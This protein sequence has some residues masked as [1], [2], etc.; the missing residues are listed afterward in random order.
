[1]AV[2]ADCKL[3]DVDCG[4]DGLSIPIG[5]QWNC[6]A[7][8]SRSLRLAFR[9]RC[10]AYFSWFLSASSWRGAAVKKLPASPR[11]SFTFPRLSVTLRGLVAE[12]EGEPVGAAALVWA[13]REDHIGIPGAR[14]A[15]VRRGRVGA[16]G[17]AMR[18]EQE[19][20]LGKGF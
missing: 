16:G 13:W 18:Q 20:E 15:A 5:R 6:A 2:L 12:T 3:L 19:D 9:W 11:C 8:V 14:P 17:L 10:A 7:G 4:P 1:M